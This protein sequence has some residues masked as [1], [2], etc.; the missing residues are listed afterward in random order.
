M[1]KRSMKTDT[2][3]AIAYAIKT[4]GRKPPRG[5]DV[6]ELL[7]LFAETRHEEEQKLA[8]HEPPRPK[9]KTKYS[10]AYMR[11]VSYVCRRMPKAFPNGWL[12]DDLVS[13]LR[14]IQRDV[15]RKHER[16]EKERAA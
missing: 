2:D 7:A 9:F 1:K 12:I 4:F 16:R 5:T 3:R 14:A 8:G 6:E 11:A 13:V 10:N 15:R